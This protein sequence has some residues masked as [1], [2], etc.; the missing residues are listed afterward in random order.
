MKK[1][2]KWRSFEDKGKDQKRFQAAA[3]H[4]DQWFE[5]KN[6]AFRVFYV[7]KAGGKGN[8]CFTLTLAD[9]WDKLHDDPLATGQRWYC[10]CGAK[11]KT[12]YGVLTEL[13]IGKSAYYA[14]AEF[15]PQSLCDAKFMAIQEKFKRVSTA[16]E[17][18]ASSPQIT[19][20][21]IGS[22][23]TPTMKFG[24]YKINK[25]MFADLPS[26]NW[27]QLYNLSKV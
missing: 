11:Y 4:S 3:D 7:C 25:A 2:N 23:L 14:M 19:P 15:P 27:F 24:S 21:A 17:L 16:E 22:V 5:T 12:K 8:E 20:S 1:M 9:E 26:F 6:T 10:T 13:V 18:L